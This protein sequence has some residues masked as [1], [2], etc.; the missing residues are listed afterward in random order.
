VSPQ[1]GRTSHDDPYPSTGA[2]TAAL[3][4]FLGAVIL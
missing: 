4:R 1:A 2:A 3:H